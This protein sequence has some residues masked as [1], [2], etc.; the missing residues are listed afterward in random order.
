MKNLT[1]LLL[2]SFIMFG[3]SN[4]K[5]GNVVGKWYEPE[6]HYMVVLPITIP[7]GKSVTVIMVP[8]YMTDNEDWCV[9]IMGKIGME[10]VEETVYV[11]KEQYECLSVGSH[12]KLGEDCSLSDDNNVKIKQ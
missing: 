6:S 4:L 1:T 2:A 11:T 8:Y 10:Q 9:K 3:C 12:L 7:S 5:E